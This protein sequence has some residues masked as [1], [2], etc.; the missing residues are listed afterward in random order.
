MTNLK[1]GLVVAGV[2]LVSMVSVGSYLTGQDPAFQADVARHQA[3][4]AREAAQAQASYAQAPKQVQASQAPRPPV[5]V[6]GVCGSDLSQDEMRKARRCLADPV[7]W[8]FWIP[9]DCCPS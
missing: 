1:F 4:R 3:E 9:K 8:G 7:H 6:E 5:T 2:F